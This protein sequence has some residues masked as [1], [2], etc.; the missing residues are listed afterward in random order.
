MSTYVISDIHGNYN[1]YMDMLK[2][3]QFDDDDILYILGDILDR[4]PDPIQVILDVMKRPN[5]ELLAG[6]HCVMALECLSFLLK[7]ITQES[8][9]DLDR[10]MFGKLLNWRQNGASTTI[11]EFLKYDRSIQQEILAFISELDVYDEIEV[12]GKTFILVH[13]G[14]GNFS[15][16][17]QLWEYELNELVWDRPDYEKMYFSDKYVIS[18]HTPTLAIGSNPRPGYIYQANH[19]IAI[20]CGSSFPGGRLACLRLNDMKEFYVEAMNTPTY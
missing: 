20:D 14:L 10:E 12:A 3:I 17:K 15:P 4:G 18:G 7:E 13:A 11:K 9:A 5:V 8:L 19:H 16:E 2:K 6:N 1:A